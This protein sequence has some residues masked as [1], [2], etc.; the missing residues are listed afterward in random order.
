MIRRLNGY[1]SVFPQGKH[2]AVGPD[3]LRAVLPNRGQVVLY[4]S[5]RSGSEEII[6]NTFEARKALDKKSFI[7]VL[8]LFSR[9]SMQ[10]LTSGP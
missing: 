10:L 8:G 7:G 2:I 3:Y 4:Y 5:E 6:P 1:I 9:K